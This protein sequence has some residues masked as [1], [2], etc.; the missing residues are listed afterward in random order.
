LFFSPSIS[1]YFFGLLFPTDF[2]PNFLLFI[3]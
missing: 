3:K 1:P 2:P